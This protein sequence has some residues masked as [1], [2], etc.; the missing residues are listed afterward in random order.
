MGEPIKVMIVDDHTLFRQGL[1]KVLE[2]YR[3]IQVIG[4]ASDGKEAIV[5]VGELQPDVVLMDIKMPRME[6]FESTR[7]I[8]E[9]YPE[10]VIIALTMYEDADYVVKM[11]HAGANGYMHKDISVDK[12]VDAIRHM[13]EGVVPPFYLA[14]G[15]ETLREVVPTGVRGKELSRQ[16]KQTLKLMTEGNSNKES[17]A[18]LSLSDQTIKGYVRSI[19]QKLGASSRAQAVAIALNK[20]LIE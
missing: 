4:E 20:S 8:R 1:R 11:V 3:E 14:V 12:L 16:E 6:G 15:A 10:L 17:A 19:F 2:T 13:H 5:R 7:L 9:S 18:K